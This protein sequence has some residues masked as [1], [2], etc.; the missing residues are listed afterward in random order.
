M[1]LNT[2]INKKHGTTV[3]GIWIYLPISKVYF[4]PSPPASASFGACVSDDLKQALPLPPAPPLAARKKDP[5]V[6]SS[7]RISL[8][9]MFLNIVPMGTLM[10]LKKELLSYKDHVV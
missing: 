2:K 9:S 4:S 10:T 5:S 8:V 6:V 3:D 7:V 1:L